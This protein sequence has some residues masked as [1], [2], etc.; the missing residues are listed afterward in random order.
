MRSEE[1]ARAAGSG[2]RHGQQPIRVQ[3]PVPRL[4]ARNMGNDTVA[5]ALAPP[6]WRAERGGVTRF[7]LLSTQRSG[8]S[9]VMERLAAHPRIG[10]Y[11]ELLLM[12]HEGWPGWPPGAHDRPVYKTYLRERGHVNSTW[13]RHR[14]LFHTL[15]TSSRLVGAM[16][17]SASK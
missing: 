15:T 14:H 4:P 8:T 7:I 17:L 11:G 12:N 13:D 9:W 6:R 16:R 10:S 5:S 1:A 3:S 2:S